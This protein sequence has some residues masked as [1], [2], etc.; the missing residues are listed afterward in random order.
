M[1]LTDY[2]QLPFAQNALV[3]GTLIAVVCGLV[4][5]FVV[6]RNMAFAVHGTAELSFTGAAAGLLVADDPILG[7]L[8]G[9]LV[10]ATAFGLLGWVVY[11]NKEQVRGVLSHRA[12][13]RLLAAA[14]AVYLAT[15]VCTFLRW[16]ALV[17][18][19]EPKF[20]R[21][22]ALLLGFIGNVFNLVIPGAVGGDF[23]KAAYLVR[24]DINRTQAVA[25]MVIDA[26][27]P[28]TMA[29]AKVPLSRE[30]R[31]MWPKMARLLPTSTHEAATE[32]AASVTVLLDAVTDA[33]TL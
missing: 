17:R 6:S 1:G 32:P 21:R 29:T 10:V 30:V 3:A 22:D 16:Y 7:A 4:G 19:I 24:M 11:Q 23:I 28:E 33:S 9:S 8:L 25:S 15:L 18:V 12:D 20:T 13:F 2:L 26:S 5:P 27:A 31:G 14:L